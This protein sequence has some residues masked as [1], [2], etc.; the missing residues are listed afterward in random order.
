VDLQQLVAF[1]VLSIR[2]PWA[3]FVVSGL[4][5]VELRTWPTNYRGW[6]WIHAGKLFDAGAMEILGLSPEHF[7]R[8]GLVGI[9]HLAS[10]D[11]IETPQQWQT[12][13]NEHRSPGSF[14]PGVY[15]WHF[16]D[17]IALTEKIETRGQTL[18]YHLDDSTRRRVRDHIEASPLHYDF[19]DAIALL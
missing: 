6:M 5:S 11:V 13:R 1:P 2:Q 18:L 7:R 16:D 10:C 9:A 8:G 15:G 4:K 19:I 17:A 14:R 3:S 12:L